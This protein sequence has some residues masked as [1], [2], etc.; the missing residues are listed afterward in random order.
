M[1]ARGP[2]GT[3]VLH[4]AATSFTSEELREFLGLGADLLKNARNDA[5]QLPLDMA[6]SEGKEENARLLM[7]TND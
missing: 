7:P 6:R 4:E 1:S 3:T 2:G 5:G